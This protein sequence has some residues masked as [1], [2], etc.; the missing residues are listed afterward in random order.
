[1][2]H[3][4]L[5]TYNNSDIK[6]GYNNSIRFYS[7]KRFGNLTVIG[8]KCSTRKSHTILPSKALFHSR[9]SDL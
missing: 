6:A 9:H 2:K 8:L 4:R 3:K 7:I 1:M 5:L